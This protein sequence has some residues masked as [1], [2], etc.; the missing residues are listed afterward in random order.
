MA[1]T[2]PLGTRRGSTMTLTSHRDYDGHEKV[3]WIHDSASGLS[4]P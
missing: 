3:L 2:R 1:R 4:I